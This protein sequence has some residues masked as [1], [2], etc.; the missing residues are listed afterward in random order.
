M[1]RKSTGRCPNRIGMSRTLP[2]LP[3]YTAG[4]SGTFSRPATTTRTPHVTSRSRPQ[5]PAARRA[6][7]PLW[8]TSPTAI[9]GSPR[10]T[11]HATVTGSET[12]TLST[13]PL[14]RLGLGRRPLRGLR[15]RHDCRLWE[16]L[17]GARRLQRRRLRG[18]ERRPTGGRRRPRPH[19]RQPALVTPV[20][21]AA[22]EP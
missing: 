17:G 6:K 20:T 5:A 15:L 7:R 3:A 4:P 16:D 22:V 13:R 1:M 9:D 12:R 18:H 11:V 8:S 21:L 14:R 19:R 2:W 10:A